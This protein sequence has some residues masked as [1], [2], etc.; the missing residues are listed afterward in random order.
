M[1]DEI[2]D[3]KHTALYVEDGLILYDEAKS[4]STSASLLTTWWNEAA[5]PGMGLFGE[6]YMLFSIGLM[7]PFWMLL[8]PECFAY[9]VCSP[10]LLSSL[11]YSVVLGVI[12]GMILLGYYANLIGRRI[13]GITTASFMC[14]GA[15]GLTGVSFL[16]SDNP[17]LLFRSMSVLLFIFGVGV[18]GEYPISSSTATEKAMGE[19]RRNLKVELQREAARKSGTRV[20]TTGADTHYT[21]HLDVSGSTQTFG[22]TSHH[23]TRGRAVQLVFLS[24]GIGI[25]VNSLSLAFL[26]LLFGQYGSQVADGNYAAEALLSIWR[27]VYSFGAI[28]LTTVFVSRLSYLKESTVWA[29]DK[30]RRERLDRAPDLATNS[31]SS[32]HHQPQCSSTVSETSEPSAVSIGDA[33]SATECMPAANAF[34]DISATRKFRL[35]FV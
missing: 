4:A 14:A 11:T 16:F 5:W 23:A 32:E 18:G 31:K 12:F 17:N 26:L 20:T 7:K 10:R 34:Y 22:E 28:V 35:H 2:P 33:S 8:Y 21:R 9:E 13:G 6:S 1:I 29:E 30:E 24:Q 15:V 27:I 25:L 3:D 19:M